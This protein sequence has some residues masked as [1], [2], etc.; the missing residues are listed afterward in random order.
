MRNPRASA[1]ESLHHRTYRFRI[2]GMGL[3]G[4]PVAVVL[5]ETAAT[6]PLW[7]W[8]VFGCL[9]WPHLAYAMA[10]SS[11]DPFAAER[12]NLAIDSLIAGSMVPLMQFNLLPSV[13]LLTVTTADKINSG[14][15]N[16]WLRSLPGMVL[17]L[18]C[19]RRVD[20]LRLAARHQHGRAARQPA[21]AR[22]PH[23]GRQPQRLPPDPQGPET[24]PAAG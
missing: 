11:A 9:L 19:L 12:R 13:V 6:W 4:V 5:A 2:L 17:G 7:A 3:G 16:L 18:A 1:L 14:I 8:M 21:P 24:E 10:R 20:R 15:R 23:P 22:H